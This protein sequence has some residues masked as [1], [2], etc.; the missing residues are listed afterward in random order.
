[1][2]R[3]V[4]GA[5]PQRVMRDLNAEYDRQRRWFWADPCRHRRGRLD[6]PAAREEVLGRA[7]EAVGHPDGVLA[8]EAARQFVA[9]HEAALV[10]MPAARA[11]L[12][13]ARERC[14][15]VVLLTNG[16][17]GPQRAKLERFGLLDSFDHIQIEGAFGCG[18]PEPRAFRACL[19]AVAARPEEAAM[20]G[21][22]W[23]HDVV[24]ALRS[25]LDAVWVD[26][27][28]RGPP[29]NPPVPHATIH[30]IGELPRRLER[31]GGLA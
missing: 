12:A 6:L 14:E 2:E 23:E 8:R 30:T 26:L 28:R 7:L 21:N 1:M 17:E 13:R 18:K 16:A 22:D 29:G 20:V 31:K 9:A 5:L 27:E 10:L 11:V 25:G 15:R 19:D 4:L 3:V 24:G